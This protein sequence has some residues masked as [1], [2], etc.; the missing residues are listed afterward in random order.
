M[1][2]ILL[3][4]CVFIVGC[5]PRSIEEEVLSFID[6][7]ICF[8]DSMTVIQNEIITSNSLILNDLY[9]IK[10]I[11]YYSPNRCTPCIIGRL[12]D[13]ERIFDLEVENQF[14]PQII[15]ASKEKTHE[16][17]AL[18]SELKMQSLQFP[19]YIDKYDEFRRLNPC[20]PK[21]MNLHAFL[22]DKNNKVVLVGNPLI[23]EAMWALFKSTLEN[24]LAHD[25]EYVPEK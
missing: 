9:P 19:V 21:N 18:I 16:Y 13:Y 15:L 23:N 17:K 12:K 7:T 8:P 10:L 24:M 1:R 2:K 3:L 14:S 11:L 22:L 6:K 4:Y 20:L 5:S 25:G